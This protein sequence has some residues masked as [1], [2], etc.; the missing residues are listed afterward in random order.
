MTRMSLRLYMDDNA[1]APVRESANAAAVE[2]MAHRNASAVHAEGRAAR[3]AVDKARHS[4]AAFA[5]AREDDVIFTASGSEANVLALAPDLRISGRAVT[6]L[7]VS[8]IEHPSVAAGGRFGGE[9]TEII[10]VFE[11]GVVNLK[12]LEHRLSG[13]G[14][15][16]VPFVSIMAANNETGVIQPIAATANIVHA[17]GGVLHCDAVQVAGRTDF[18]EATEGADL[19]SISAHKLGGLTGAGALV[20][21]NGAIALSPLVTGGGQERNRRAGTEAVAAIAAFGAAVD[22]AQ[23]ES[24]LWETVATCR[25]EIESHILNTAADAIIAGRDAPRLPNTIQV[26]V[27]GMKA[28]TAVI[29]FDLAGAAISSGSACSSGKVTAS[30]VLKAMG[31]S[32]EHSASAVRISLPRTTTAEEAERFCAIWDR[33]I[34]TLREGYRNNAFN[35]N[36]TSVARGAA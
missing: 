12:A 6:H 32:D 28:E 11:T 31:F 26:V 30:P 16:S 33:V 29:A 4:I 25:D 18:A 8:A 17:H 21:R 14:V 35:E 2:A 27:P 5:V 23:T 7:L 20:V 15:D 13:L 3:A 9:R 34:G 10:P 36:D 19:V 1:S 24:K 22:E